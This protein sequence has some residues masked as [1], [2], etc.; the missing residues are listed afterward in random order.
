MTTRDLDI[1]QVNAFREKYAYRLGNSTHS[2]WFGVG[3]LISKGYTF[4]EALDL[5]KK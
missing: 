4:S 2:R 1:Q 5:L 3:F